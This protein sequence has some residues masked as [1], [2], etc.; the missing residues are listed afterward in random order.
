MYGAVAVAFLRATFHAIPINLSSYHAESTAV[1]ALA[2]ICLFEKYNC[3]IKKNIPQRM[4][5]YNMSSNTTV[6]LQKLQE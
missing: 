3:Y 2:G 6:I 5:Q 4:Y 1:Y